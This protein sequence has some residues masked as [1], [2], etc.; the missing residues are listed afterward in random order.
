[1]APE[2]VFPPGKFNRSEHVFRPGEPYESRP[3]LSESTERLV[4]QRRYL[5]ALQPLLEILA[6]NPRDQE[7]LT[8]ALLVVG[9]A[10]AE[11]AQAGEA[12]GKEHLHDRRL[13]PIFAVCSHCRKTSWAPQNCLFGS[14]AQVLS[15]VGVQCRNC[16]YVVCRSCTSGTKICPNCGMPALRSPVYPTGREPRQL[17]RG[18]KP[19]VRAVVFREG[20]VAP[21]REW[22]VQLFALVSPDA[23][24]GEV[25]WSALPA[26]PW[27]SNM[28]ELA[29]A[30]AARMLK[31]GLH[32]DF[33]LE[34][35][36]G[37]EV[38]AADG[39]RAYVLKL[40]A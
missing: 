11:R 26:F 16:G 37:A 28:G 29:L 25:Q 9:A 17:A 23:L 32:G 31:G 19:L 12:L 6:E 5:S 30:V 35:S 15:P 21:E 8:L 14:A 1:M 34:D 10:Q 18:R 36:I 13:D 24:E 39:S 27:R 2:K 40:Y 3:G 33:R 7:A 38:R 20:R 22:L 4:L